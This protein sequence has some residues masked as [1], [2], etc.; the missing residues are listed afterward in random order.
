ML[1]CLYNSEKK[2]MTHFK[3][4]LEQFV[5]WLER[6][7]RFLWGK[8]K[9]QPIIT[10]N[11]ESFFQETASSPAEVDPEKENAYL[12]AELEEK[13]LLFWQ[14]RKKS[15]HLDHRQQTAVFVLLFLLCETDNLWTGVR[16]VKK[17]NL[18][19]SLTKETRGIS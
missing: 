10:K 12:L 8:E 2:L 6:K 16:H 9:F 14:I 15:F 3:N 19:N 13:A 1:S 7:L 11:K 17:K 4:P 18:T 5:D